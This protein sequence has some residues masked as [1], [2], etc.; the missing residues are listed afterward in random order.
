MKTLIEDYKRRLVTAEKM[1]KEDE[2]PISRVGIERLARLQ[3]KASEYRTFIAELEREYKFKLS[4]YEE[5][6][7]ISTYCGCDADI[8]YTDKEEAEKD[9]KEQYEE[10]LAHYRKVNKRM[11]DEEWEEYV[12]K[13][14]ANI[15]YTVITLDQAIDNIKDNIRDEHY[16][17]GD[18]SY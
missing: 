7:V 9:A 6:W 4:S 14:Y 18:P 16:S 13:T 3:T 10:Y 5:V 15:K 11:S 2:T 1:I 17:Y 12:K 8:V